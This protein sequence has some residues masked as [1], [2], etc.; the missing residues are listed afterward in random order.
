MDKAK[1]KTY[2]NYVYVL[3]TYTNET[4]TTMHDVYSSLK[5][6]NKAGEEYLN[7]HGLES[8]MGVVVKKGTVK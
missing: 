6:A 7:Q 2:K 4:D 1:R 5:K 3:Y 8:V